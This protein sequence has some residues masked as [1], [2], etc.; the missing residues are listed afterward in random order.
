MSRPLRVGLNLFHVAPG[1]G[2]TLTYARELLRALLEVEPQT[3]V[4][5]FASEQLPGGFRESRGRA[6]CGGSALRVA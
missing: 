1:A 4:V 6:T 2:G 3:R 5:A